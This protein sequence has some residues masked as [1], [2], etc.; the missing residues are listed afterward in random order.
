LRD[1]LSASPFLSDAHQFF[2]F[3]SIT[4]DQTVPKIGSSIFVKI[5]SLDNNSFM[6]ITFNRFAIDVFVLYVHSL[7]IFS[8]VLD[9]VSSPELEPEVLL[10]PPFALPPFVLIVTSLSTYTCVLISPV[11]G[12]TKCVTSFFQKQ[13]LMSLTRRFLCSLVL[14]FFRQSFGHMTALVSCEPNFLK[15]KSGN[16]YK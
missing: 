9:I 8:D 11:N 15:R 1:S 12:H 7:L 16:C 4:S 6:P 13:E 10:Y 14:C 3:S 2:S 5:T